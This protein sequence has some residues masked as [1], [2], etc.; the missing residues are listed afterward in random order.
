[1]PAGVLE[2]LSAHVDSKE[3]ALDVA[4]LID[5]PL[6]DDWLTGG[7]IPGANDFSQLSQLFT[8]YFN[9]PRTVKMSRLPKSVFT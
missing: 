3:A 7:D 2:R 6:H 5:E 8:G 1:M 9:L 4:D